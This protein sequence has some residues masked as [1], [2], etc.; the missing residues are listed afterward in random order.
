[1]NLSLDKVVFD[2]NEKKHHIKIN[3]VGHVDHVN[4]SA[5]FIY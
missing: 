4:L 1:M 2:N 5:N 3:W